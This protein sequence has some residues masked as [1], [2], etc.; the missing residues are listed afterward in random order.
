MAV[1]P[2]LGF[3]ATMAIMINVINATPNLWA[4]VSPSIILTGIYGFVY[5]ASLLKMPEYICKYKL[6][7]HEEMEKLLAQSK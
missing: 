3:Q 1:F 2:A 5:A 6:E 7:G 4:T